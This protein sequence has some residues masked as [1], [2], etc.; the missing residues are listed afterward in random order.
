[1]AL[2]IGCDVCKRFVR[3]IPWEKRSEIDKQVICPE[4]IKKRQNL[5][6]YIEKIKS[7]T[8]HQLSQIYQKAK[9]DLDEMI[10]EIAHQNVNKEE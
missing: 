10:T 6:S 4:C 7:R 5:D 9:K 8:E 3:A 1:M 2:M